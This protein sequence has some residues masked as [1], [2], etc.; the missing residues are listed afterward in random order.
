M[1]SPTVPIV[2]V[3]RRASLALEATGEST[4]AS[5]PRTPPLS[6][7]SG[8]ASRRSAPSLCPSALDGCRRRV[9][10]DLHGHRGRKGDPLYTARHTLH[11]GVQLLTAR[12]EARLELPFA[13]DAHL[14]VETTWSVYQH[15]VIAYRHPDRAEG[16][17]IL[18]SVID[19][20]S[21]GVPAGLGELASG[22]GWLRSF[23]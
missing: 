9:Q 11:T 7:V 15:I 3:V 23:L 19:K 20:L 18:A 5:P 1:C 4:W 12:Q 8:G 10:Q 2:T 6:P 22:S 13:D 17:S 16:R 21:T 14:P